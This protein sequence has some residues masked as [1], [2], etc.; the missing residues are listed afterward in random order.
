MNA[1]KTVTEPAK[2]TIYVRDTPVA[3]A[4]A[5][6]G[7]AVLLLHG[8]G[9]TS[10]DW[11]SVLAHL[12]GRHRAVAVDLPGY[13]SSGPIPD[14]SPAGIAN[15]LWDVADALGLERP[16][17]MGHSE[18]G[19]V[20]A[21]MAFA[22]PAR[23]PRLVLVSASGMGRAIHPAFILMGT[24]PLGALFPYLAKL[25]GGPESLVLWLALAGS[26]RPWR[27]PAS[28]ATK[29]RQAASS[30]GV[31]AAALSTIRQATSLRGQECIVADRLPELTMPALVVWG[32][33]DTILPAFQARRAAARLGHGQLALIPLAG[34]LLPIE[35][36]DALLAVAAPFL[37]AQPLPD[38]ANSAEH[39]TTSQTASSTA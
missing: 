18:G 3:Y 1:T 27:I 5:G 32:K 20:A 2:Q 12:A 6:D 28:W 33:Q 17:L 26:P 16:A 30:T 31:L 9:G 13:G 37:A 29:M 10:E 35:A 22:R 15:F 23:V 39:D 36:P 25:P 24:T 11:N 34:H 14:S 8:L 38:T 19:G 21:E 7:P 4:E